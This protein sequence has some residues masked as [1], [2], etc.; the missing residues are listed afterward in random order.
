VDADIYHRSREPLPRGGQQ[1][2]EHESAGAAQVVEV[3]DYFTERMN[4]KLGGSYMAWSANGVRPWPESTW[5]AYDLRLFSTAF[6]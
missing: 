4:G 3:K 6:S 2:V 1:Q 5:S